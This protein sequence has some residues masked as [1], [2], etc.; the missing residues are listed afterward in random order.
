MALADARD[1]FARADRRSFA[2]LRAVAQCPRP[3]HW[4]IG[5]F[6]EPARRRAGLFFMPVIEWLRLAVRE[7]P[8]DAGP[9]AWG[10]C[11][12]P[13]LP[14]STQKR[15]GRPTREAGAAISHQGD[16]AHRSQRAA[17]ET[18]D[19]A[20]GYG[21]PVA[22]PGGALFLLC[23]GDVAAATPPGRDRRGAAGRGARRPDQARRRAAR[24]SQAANER[25]RRRPVLVAVT[26]LANG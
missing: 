4:S 15:N 10:S 13:R 14:R 26:R 25:R 12:T 22:E 19:R 8:H 6:S 18:A 24:G 16:F 3:P 23:S 5:S 21:T 2:A 17:V 1:L 9:Q 7:T 20:K 11:V